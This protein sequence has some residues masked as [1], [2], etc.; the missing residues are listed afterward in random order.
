MPYNPNGSAHTVLTDLSRHGVIRYSVAQRMVAGERQTVG[1]WK[2]AHFLLVTM[3][4][5]GLIRWAAPDS[6]LIVMTREG[7][8]ALAD[9]DAGIDVPSV[10]PVGGV[11]FFGREAA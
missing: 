4:D 2:K 1:A 10:A 3:M 7:R 9:L 11:R 8:E 6:H 5:G